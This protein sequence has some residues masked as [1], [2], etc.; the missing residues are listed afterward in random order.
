MQVNQYI[1]LMNTLARFRLRAEAR[2]FG[3]GY[4]WWIL[5]PLMYVGVFYLVF[6][7]LLGNR[8][9][10]FLFFLA[11]AC[12]CFHLRSVSDSPF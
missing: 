6:V 9:P 11:V 5:E 7:L 3:L 8:E 1:T 10:D 2:V 12:H 4:F